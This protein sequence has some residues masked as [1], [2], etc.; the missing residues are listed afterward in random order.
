MTNAD[1]RI[2]FIETTFQRMANRPGGLTRSQ[3]VARANAHIDDMKSGFDDY[4]DMKLAE[5]STIVMEAEVRPLGSQEID[6]AL[7]C[8]RELRDTG[9]TMGYDFMT[10]VA[11]NFCAIWE[12][13]AG[14]TKV[15]ADILTC[16]IDALLLSRSA[17]LH[18]IDTQKV[19]EISEGLVRVA[20]KVKTTT[21]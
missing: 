15:E 5:L 1:A 19:N 9:T 14:G 11:R 13:M 3:A 18:P 17:R 12:A 8:C 7:A 10:S 6:R 2:F 21:C 20:R 16:H 4:A